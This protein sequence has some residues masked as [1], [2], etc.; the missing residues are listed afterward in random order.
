M[1][2]NSLFPLLSLLLILTLT[3]SWCYKSY[4]TV[5]GESTTLDISPD[6]AYM[7]VTA[8][9]QNAVYVY[10]ILN[11]NLLLNYTPSAGTVVTARFSR[12][13]VYLGIAANNGANAAITLLSGRSTFNSTTLIN[14]PLTSR[15]IA[16]IDFN[17]NSTK[18]LACYSNGNKYEIFNNYTGV[19]TA[20]TS[21]VTIAN[22]IVKCRFSQNDDVGYIDTNK[23]TKI[24]RP[25]GTSSTSITN[26]AANYKN[27][28]IRQT[29]ATPIKFIAAGS[30]T[31][32]YYATDTNPGSMTANSYSLTSILSS[33]VMTS[34]CYS[35]DSLFYASAGGGTDMRIFIFADNDTLFQ[36]FNEPTLTHLSCRFTPD[37]SYLYFGTAASSSFSNVYIY[38]KN[39]F[40]C[41]VG[42]FL[43]GNNTC[44]LCNLA[45]GML[46]C[47]SC[48]NT[49]TCTSC[50]SG[51]Y[52]NQTN[53]LCFKCD[54]II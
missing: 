34:A 40:E 35:G 12:D 29:T 10:D 9:P 39:C 8:V 18:L 49:T 23:G 5:P 11:N 7:A 13:G 44:T 1:R 51:Y 47:S 19:G 15:N 16:D 3:H 28:D 46:Y 36:V 54:Y 14:F 38:K 6:S 31:K 48:V 43:T 37:G 26:A 42:Y 53:S 25:A 17:Q 32:S 2:S 20:S 41:P 50:F 27:F 33:G 21:S 24:Y 30:D 4:F 52:L 45:V 22:N